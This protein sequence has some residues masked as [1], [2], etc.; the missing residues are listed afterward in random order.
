MPQVPF[1]SQPRVSPN[2]LP[3]VRRSVNAPIEAFGG[4]VAA[5]QIDLSG[6]ANV[7]GNIA[8][9][10]ALDRQRIRS[11]AAL[12]ADQVAV[13]HAV[14]ATTIGT[15]GIL[16]GPNGLF[17]RKGKDA[18][19]IDQDAYDQYGAMVA[20]IRSQLTN[21]RQRA[22]YDKHVLNQ[23]DAIDSQVQPYIAAQ[24]QRFDKE[25]VE[26][27]LAGA[28]NAA[29]QAPLNPVVVEQA[30]AQSQAIA[31][32]YAQRLGMPDEAVKAAGAEAASD[33]HLAV[34]QSMLSQ[35]T[36][37]NRDQMASAYYDAHKD[38][39]VGKD[40][41]DAE[42]LTKA[43]AVEGDV[44]RTTDKIVG[45]T[46]TEEGAYAEA[47]KIENGVLREKVEQRISLVYNRKAGIQRDKEK[48]AFESGYK[49]L[50]AHNYD[51]YS[52]PIT[53]RE[54]MG[55]MH[56]QN[57]LAESQQ[58]TRLAAKGG[59]GD[60]EA[61]LMLTNEAGIDPEAFMNRKILDVPGLNTVQ[62]RRLLSL[63]R[64]ISN[65][66][67][68]EEE[69]PYRSE[70]TKATKDLIE[71]KQGMDANPGDA[72]WAKAWKDAVL[73]KVA[74]E[75]ALRTRGQQVGSMPHSGATSEEEPA[76]S[77]ID[78]IKAWP[79]PPAKKPK[80]PTRQMLD[81]IM[82]KGPGYAQYLRESGYLIPDGVPTS[83]PAEA[84]AAE[85]KPAVHET[86]VKR[87]PDGKIVS[88]TTTVTKPGTKP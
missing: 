15:N 6:P 79:N 3:G 52:I 61:E 45:A 73:A 48:A 7:A 78:K 74:A 8:Q 53:T 76:S 20:E 41:L 32:S 54:A 11:E 75:N 27:G 22:V 84:K 35:P 56:F 5:Q 25:G 1:L 67:Q 43:S 57:L 19:T 24:R 21:D 4:G 18:F 28:K 9:Q 10:N 16:H 60:D 49:T 26:T 51:P 70:L 13:T 69:A 85:P 77:M 83:P 30:V 64:V 33:V 47:A 46:T 59:P 36:N 87:G 55:A 81:D 65:R 71:A 23:W 72:D 34:I 39:L 38:G 66:I 17:N 12:E 40:R 14:S 31:Q 86:V 2:A 80:P 68:R 63:Q 50:L 62:Q 88:T 29:I 42:R 37:P 44:L 82:R 58:Q